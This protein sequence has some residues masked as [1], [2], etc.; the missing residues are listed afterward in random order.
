MTS[1]RRPRPLGP[2]VLALCL[3]LPLAAQRAEAR[4][5]PLA[6][7][8]GKIVTSA[9]PLSPSG[10]EEAFARYLDERQQAQIG[11]AAEG[12]WT[13]HLIAFFSKPIGDST[14]HVAIYDLSGGKA[15]FV[16]AQGQQ[17]QAAQTNLATQVELSPDRFKAGQAYELRVT[18]LVK[19]KERVYA[20]ARIVLR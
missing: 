7:F 17:V 1:T 6:R 14:C 9:T 2:I 11:R 12:P 18:R 13:V 15:R 10:E 16:E 19:G 8:A 3:L 20:R 4:K 5:S